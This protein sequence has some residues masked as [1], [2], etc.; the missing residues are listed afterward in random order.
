MSKAGHD[1]MQNHTGKAGHD[2]K[3]HAGKANHE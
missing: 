3:S 2:L 1:M